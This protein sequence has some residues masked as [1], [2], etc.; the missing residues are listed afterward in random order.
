MSHKTAWRLAL[1][2]T[3]AAALSAPLMV[4]AQS[5]APRVVIGPFSGYDGDQVAEKLGGFLELHN[6]E[7]EAIPGSTYFG[8]ASR[9]GLDGRLGEEDIARVSREIRAD[10]VIVGDLTRNGRRHVLRLRI[11]RGRDGVMVGTINLEFARVNDLDSLEGDLW[12]ELAQHIGQIR[13]LGSNSFNNNQNSS[14]QSN[15]FNQNNS[16]NNNH[17]SSNSNSGDQSTSDASPS[18]DESASH[19]PGLGVAQLSVGAGSGS[20]FWRLAIVGDATAREHYVPAYFESRLEGRTYIRL[21]NDRVGLGL[22]AMGF[23]PIALSS[24]AYNMGVMVQLP[25]SAFEVDAGLCLAYLPPSGGAFRADAGFVL[26]TIDVK[27]DVL[28]VT[29]QLVRMSYPGARLR[30]E[31]A[32]P[33]FA[34]GLYEFALLFAGELRLASVGAEARAALGMTAALT[35]AFG[36]GG[37]FELRLDG[38][39]PGLSARVAADWLRYRTSF[40][41]ASNLGNARDSVDDFIR[42]EGIVSYA[43]GVRTGLAATAAASTTASDSSSSSS[44][45]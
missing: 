19:L 20:R 27:T 39:A 23:L 34:N 10:A 1:A 14:N 44:S 2:N 31:A 45:N 30:S 16:S 8:V 21:Q 38:V 26:H 36:G 5:Q 24:Y 9:L 33:L 4:Q 29:Q 41:G 40:S 22:F 6:G 43:F 32:V 7:I 11:A 12:T 42:V 13:P 28:P 25:T 15:N 35:S 37:G 18:G 3:F 17:T